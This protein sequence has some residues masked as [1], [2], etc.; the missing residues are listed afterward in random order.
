MTDIHKSIVTVSNHFSDHR[1]L[2]QPLFLS[3]PVF[4]ETCIDFHECRKALH[5]WRTLSSEE[6]SIRT[7]EYSALLQELS[8][9]LLDCLRL[10]EKERAVNSKPNK[11]ENKR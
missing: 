6:A 10:F 4:R 11:G 2:I 5:Y 7:Q 8:K 9:E 3:N 1:P